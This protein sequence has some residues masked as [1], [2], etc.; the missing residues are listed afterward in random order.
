MAPWRVIAKAA[1]KGQALV[2]FALILPLLL[3]LL[4]GIIEFGR[5][6]F[7]K[8]MTIN[9]ARE[10]ARFA[11]VQTTWDVGKI[12]LAATNPIVPESLKIGSTVLVVPQSRPASGGPVK[13]TVNTTFRTLFPKWLVPL[14]NYTNISASA[15]MRYEQ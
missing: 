11:V 9:A 8:N 4:F 6:F 15:T 1:E 7:Q 10:G 13:V 3:L 2:E 14:Q 5:A 12:K